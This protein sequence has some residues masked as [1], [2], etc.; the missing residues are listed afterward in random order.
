MVEAFQQPLLTLRG[1]PR[2]FE[3]ELVDLAIL[4]VVAVVAVVAGIAV[5]VVLA[6]LQIIVQQLLD[7]DVVNLAKPVYLFDLP[8][9]DKGLGIV[10]LQVEIL[11]LE[12]FDLG[13][14]GLEILDLEIL[15]VDL[16]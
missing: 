10:I 13:T 1:A 6:R 7:Q 4:A 2:G 5:L 8:G 9:L 3:Q 16:A 11:G 14:P 15:V 12:V